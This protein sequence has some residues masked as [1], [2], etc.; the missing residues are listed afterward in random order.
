[1][2]I[3]YSAQ[4]RHAEE[5]KTDKK[6]KVRDY[7]KSQHSKKSKE[8]AFIIYSWVKISVLIGSISPL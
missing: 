2:A 1:M 6:K 8:L 7:E 4:T 3:G 5:K